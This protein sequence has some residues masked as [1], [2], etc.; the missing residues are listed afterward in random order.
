MLEETERANVFISERRPTE[1]NF[2][3]KVSNS[4]KLFYLENKCKK[5]FGFLY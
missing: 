1:I 3:A 2:I 4:Q 5:H